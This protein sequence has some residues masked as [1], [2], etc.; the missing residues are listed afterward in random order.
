MSRLKTFLIYLL[1][2]VGF[3]VFSD[4]LINFSLNASYSTISRKDNLE[5]VVIN[6][7]EATKLN[8]RVKGTITNLEGNPITLKYV[9]IDFYS[10][11]DNIVG[12]KYIDVSNL[13]QNESMDFQIHLRLD[14]VTHYEVSFTNNKDTEEIDMPQSDMSRKDLFEISA[15]TVLMLL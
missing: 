7:A 6:Q 3:F 14:D 2:F 4:F 15:L 11:R 9:R 5:Q 1:I 10:E 12:T 8:L 13:K